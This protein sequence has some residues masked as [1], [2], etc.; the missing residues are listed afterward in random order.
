MKYLELIVS[1]GCVVLFAVE[2]VVFG[3]MIHKKKKLLHDGALF[4]KPGSSFWCVF[5]LSLVLMLLPLAIP[6]DRIGNLCIPCCG[7]LGAFVVLK[8]RLEV[9]KKALS[10]QESS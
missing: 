10:E 6:M 5:V 3:V 2:T 1:L 7:V 9:V 8:E 4:K